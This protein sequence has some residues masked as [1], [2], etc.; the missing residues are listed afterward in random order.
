MTDPPGIFCQ[1]GANAAGRLVACRVSRNPKAE[2]LLLSL[3]IQIVQ[4]NFSFKWTELPKIGPNLRI[5][6]DKSERCGKDCSTI[7]GGDGLKG[8]ADQS[9]GNG[10]GGFVGASVRAAN[11]LRSQILAGELPSGTPLREG[12]LAAAL[13]VSRNTL[14]EALRQ[15]LSEGLIEQALYRGA[16]VRRMTHADVRDIFTVR[17]TLQFRAIEMSPYASDE[18]LQALE[19]WVAKAEAAAAESD[20]LMVGTA[21]IR[22]HL[23]IVS[24]IGSPLLDRFFET[25]M[26]QLSLAL[27]EQRAE[28]SFQLQWVPRNREICSLLF[29]G[30]R[31]EA[32]RALESFITDSEKI[33]L[34]IVRGA[35]QSRLSGEG[36]RR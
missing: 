1:M 17:R 25:I 28:K 32:L 16:T 26:A 21:S 24:L 18:R 6:V 20:W 29:E 5:A 7:R 22:F 12:T 19:Q 30:R 15:L 23:A 11:A 33:V 9:E 3:A 10:E 4:R 27:E 13:G 31:E 14:R 35:E 36:G 8:L 34:D 2:P